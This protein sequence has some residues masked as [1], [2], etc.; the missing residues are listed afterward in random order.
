MPILPERPA[1]IILINS[2]EIKEATPLRLTR[3][4][5]NAAI[6][7][8]QIPRRTFL[9]L[10]DIQGE[11]RQGSLVEL[12]YGLGTAQQRVFYGYLPSVGSD[13]NLSEKESDIRMTAQDF[14]GQLADRTVTLGDSSSSFLNP[15]GDEIGGF[16][17]TNDAAATPAASSM[18]SGLR[19]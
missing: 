12:Y 3:R 14:I 7:E 19:R 6:L 18:C 15:T 17:A 5:N 16:I 9:S 4:I 11:L 13:R 8:F 1:S 10:R 2:R